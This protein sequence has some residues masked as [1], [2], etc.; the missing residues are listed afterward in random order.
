MKLIKLVFTYSIFRFSVHPVLLWNEKSH[1]QMIIYLVE[2]HS[3]LSLLSR[4]IPVQVNSKKKMLKARWAF[5]P[6]ALMTPPQEQ[7]TCL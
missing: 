7:G 5:Q 3:L 2:F 4:I 6:I 1:N